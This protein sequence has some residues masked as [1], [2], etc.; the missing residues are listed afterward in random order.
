MTR[1]NVSNELR[2]ESGRLGR[3]FAQSPALL[4]AA[5]KAVIAAQM[6]IGRTPDPLM[7]AIVEGKVVVFV[8]G[9]Y[10]NI[11]TGPGGSRH[12]EVIRGADAPAVSTDRRD[13]KPA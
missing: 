3:R 1:P 7:E 2:V 9:N 12:T 10:V 6:A 11:T 5:A 4:I 13:A 8:D